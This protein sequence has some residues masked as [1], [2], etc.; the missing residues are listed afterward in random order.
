MPRGIPNNKVQKPAE[1]PAPAVVSP[2]IIITQ[3]ADGAW[4]LQAWDVLDGQIFEALRLALVDLTARG[5]GYAPVDL[6][7][8]RQSAVVL[9]PQPAPALNA[10]RNGAKPRPARRP[11]PAS[12]H[13]D[14][15]DVDYRELM[16]S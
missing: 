10:P 7:F 11:A 6:R 9:Q 5:E 12:R 14:D 16:E 8:S 2:L 3:A 15:D 1:T 13:S 4:R